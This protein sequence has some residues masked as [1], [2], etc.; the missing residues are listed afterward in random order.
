MFFAKIQD[1]LQNIFYKKKEVIVYTRQC[2]ILNYYHLCIY[3]FRISSQS[4]IHLC[5]Q[6]LLPLVGCIRAGA[7]VVAQAQVG[8]WGRGLGQIL[9]PAGQ[10]RLL[11]QQQGGLQLLP[12]EEVVSGFLHLT[13]SRRKL[14][15][16]SSAELP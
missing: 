2:R 10:Q 3:N 16:R 12:K 1:K 5:S 14:V 15:L 7:R 4:L 11:A 6:L 8:G 13:Y 9:T